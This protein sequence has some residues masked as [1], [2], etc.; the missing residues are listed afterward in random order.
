MQLRE[1]L[2]RRNSAERPARRAVRRRQ[3]AVL[4]AVT[5]VLERAGRPLR[6]RDV[7]TAVEELLG[8]PIPFSS[9]NEALLMHAGRG[10]QRFRRLR[11]GVYEHRS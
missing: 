7:H 2:A 5:N 4:E 6:V 10:D 8:G 9:V 3:G 11:Y 1:Q